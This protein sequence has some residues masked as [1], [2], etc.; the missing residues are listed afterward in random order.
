[1]VK[2]T[3]ITIHILQF[4]TRNRGLGV[5]GSGFVPQKLRLVLRLASFLLILCYL[6]LLSEL[7]AQQPQ[8][9]AVQELF[10]VNAKFV[11]GFGPGY[12]PTAGSNLN[13][14]LA[15]GTAVCSNIVQTYAG[16]T[17]VLAPTATN[18]VYLDPSHSCA[19]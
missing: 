13:L 18:Y 2:K 17:L 6:P 14:N 1:M 5:C 19:P 9:Q 8:A 15:P 4:K 16:G 7:R 11:Q 3:E 12:W 10:P